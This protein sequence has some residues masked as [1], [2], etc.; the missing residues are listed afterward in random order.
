M[1]TGNIYRSKDLAL[2]NRISQWQDVH[3]TMKYPVLMKSIGKCKIKQ[4]KEFPLR[5]KQKYFNN[6]EN[7]LKV[8]KIN[9]IISY[10]HL[11]TN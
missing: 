7:L 3:G 10:Q 11:K 2:E 5:K 1:P 4:D 9:K 8:K 6:F